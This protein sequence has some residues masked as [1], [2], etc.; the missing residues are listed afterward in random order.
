MPIA[1]G[2]A[3]GDKSTMLDLALAPRHG[4]ALTAA[5]ARYGVAVRDWLDLSTGINPHPYPLPALS[6]TDFHRL[7]DPA[8]LS[9]LVEAARAGYGV[10]PASTV[11]AVPGSDFA[12]RL[13]PLLCPAGDVAI[14]SPTYSGHAEAWHA[15]GRTVRAVASLEEGARLAPI[16]VLVNPNNP[17]GRAFAPDALIATARALAARGGVLV[18]DEAFTDVAPALGVLPNSAGERIV[19]LRSFGKF[20][21]LAGLR[22]GFVLGPDDIV[23]ALRRQ[24]GDWPVSGPAIALGRRALLDTAWQA[25]ARVRLQAARKRLGD[26]LEQTGLEV[27]GGTDLFVLVDTPRAVAVHETLARQGIWTRIFSDQPGRIRFGLPDE[28]G[29]ARLAK[30]LAQV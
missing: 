20:Y 5:S 7:P 13:L 22:L 3:Q 12:L 24:V 15:A 19:V 21:G 30:A 2:L 8:A 11:A 14:L 10:P 1:S 23:G 4:G 18:V 26:L 17:D 9:A 27:V 16:V 28:S 6:P 25:E 29:F